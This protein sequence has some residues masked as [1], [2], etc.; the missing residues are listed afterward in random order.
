MDQYAGMYPAQRILMV[1]KPRRKFTPFDGI[2]LRA[3][4]RADSVIELCVVWRFGFHLHKRR[5]TAVEQ[6]EMVR[7]PQQQCSSAPMVREG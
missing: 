3:Y 2:G 1:R 6:P 5:S 4:D 7:I